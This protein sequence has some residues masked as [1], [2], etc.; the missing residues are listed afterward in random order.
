MTVPPPRRSRR[1]ASV[2][3]WGVVVLVVTAV[4]GPVGSIAASVSISN[5]KSEQLIQRYQ[6]DRAAQAAAA[7][8]FYCALFSSQLDA[9][10]EVTSQAGKSSR[11]AW[12]DLYQLAQ[13]E[14]A[15]K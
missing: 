11:K 14:P 12:L 6:D 3:L 4:L 8:Q 10:D 15:R 7:K 9:L 1:V 2:P 13:C 5:R